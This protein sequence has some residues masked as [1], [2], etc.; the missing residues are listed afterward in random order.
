[1]SDRRKRIFITGLIIIILITLIILVLPFLISGKVEAI[2]VSYYFE[3]N[4]PE[5]KAHHSGNAFSVMTLNLGH[6]RG[7][8]LH[9]LFQSRKKI[10]A[11]ADI[12]AA[13]IKRE[14]V[15]II[16][17]QEV[18]GP[19]FWNG[20]LDFIEYLAENSGCPHGIWTKN[21]VSPGLSYGTAL[22]SD[23]AYSH[24]ESYTF[25][26]R[27]FILPKGFTAG[28]FRIS[29]ENDVHICIV[30]VHLDP[31]FAPMRRKQAEVMIKTIENIGYPVVITGDFNCGYNKKSAVGILAEKLDLEVW[32]PESRILGTHN[33]GN[34]RLDWILI[35]RSLEFVNYSVLS[36]K[37]S[38]HSAV[39]AVI[40][41]K[42]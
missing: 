28:I 1:M 7:N 14:Q 22:L 23:L 11:N 38:D 15:D 12:I 18:D 21:V 3:Q 30:S 29:E 16:A 37:L 19:G 32:E 24:A 13:A 27:P 34:R 36:D 5:F 20:G 10:T 40:R 39:K 26:A 9:Q 33:T 25:K 31:I 4:I 41:Y 2:P 35:S 8:S 42:N 6:G 17:L